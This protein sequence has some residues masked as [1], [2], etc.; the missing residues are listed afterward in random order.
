MNNDLMFL[1][2]KSATNS[3]QLS[4]R[5]DIQ[6]NTIK[7]ILLLVPLLSPICR[8]SPNTLNCQRTPC[9]ASTGFRNCN[10]HLTVCPERL[11]KWKV[12][13]VEG[14]AKVIGEVYVPSLD[15]ENAQFT[16]IFLFTDSKRKL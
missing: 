9:F 6:C 8:C 12:I 7:W 16:Q 4:N 13:D 14:A 5:N 1:V 2:T 15:K 3:F 10:I 11:Q